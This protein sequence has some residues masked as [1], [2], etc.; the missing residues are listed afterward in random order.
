MSDQPHR[1]GVGRATGLRPPNRF[2]TIHCSD[3]WEQLEVAEQ[4]AATPRLKT[5]WLP[6]NAATIIRENDSPDI[7]FRYGINPYRGCEHGCAYCYARPTHETLGMDAGIDF[8]SKILVKH[9][10]AKL[11]RAELNRPRWRGEPIALSGVTDCY[12]PIERRF[13]ITRGLLEVLREARQCVAIV[14]KNAL[15]TRDLDLLGPMAEL[16]V[17]RVFL[18]VTTLQAD[19]ARRL[20]PRTSTPQARL[21][22]VHQFKAAGVPVGV[23]VAPVI[24]GLNDEEIP[25]ILQAASEAGACQAGFQLLRLPGA[26][27]PIFEH[28]LAERAPDKRGRVLAR[29]RDTREGKLSDPRFG[30]R[31]R[32]KGQYAEQI[33][34]TFQLFARRYGLEKKLA[35]LDTSRFRPPLPPSGQKWLFS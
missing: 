2:E 32:G 17:V 12:Q 20:E 35:P 24:P 29:I 21:Q 15:V 31:M 34:A 23:M 1:A 33:A 7:P 6:D 13:R 9:N 25:A 16:G 4:T 5:Q 10:A 3:D 30:H 19:L 14:T 22:A 26:V 28:W 18:S 11:L 27:L 8:E